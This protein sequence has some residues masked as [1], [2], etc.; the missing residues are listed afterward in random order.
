MQPFYSL[1][2]E[3]TQSQQRSPVGTS[4]WDDEQSG[5]GVSRGPGPVKK[6]SLDL[7]AGHGG[8]RRCQVGLGREEHFPEAD[9]D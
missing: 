3:A 9:S 1:L 8:P 6:W 5:V 2:K 4:W 7:A